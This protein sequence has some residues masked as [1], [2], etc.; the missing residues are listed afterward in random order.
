[1]HII[2]PIFP[3]KSL[4]ELLEFYQTLGF[5]VTY[6][7]KSPNPYAIVEK[8]WFRLD[9]YGIK[10]HDPQKCYHTCYV[11]TDET[12]EL[13]EAFTSA[14]RNKNGKLPT[15]GLPRISDIRDKKSGVREFMFSDVA[16]NCIRIGKKLDKQNVENATPEITAASERLALAL[17]FA[18]KSEDEEDEL[19]KV[20]K[21]LDKAIERDKHHY[22][23]NLYKVMILRADI[24]V[25]QGNTD[26]AIALLEEVCN[27]AEM[28][29][30]PDK[31]KA[32]LQRVA[33]VREKMK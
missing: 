1:M 16:G 7:Q 2:T 8:G 31:F 27:S 3:C 24:A 17:D 23:H 18:Y 21:V 5:E 14:L 28:V 13:Y 32:E 30:N 33:D 10:H 26:K 6:R 22:C 19:E 29:S 20:S 11:L 15:R 4:D 12:E 25:A 9:F